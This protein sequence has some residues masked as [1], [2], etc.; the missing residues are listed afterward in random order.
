MARNL[1]QKILEDHLVEGNLTP[2]GEIAIRIDHTLLQDATGTMAMAGSSRLWAF[3]G[4]R[5]KRRPST[6]T[7]ICCKPILKN[8]DDHR[9]LMTASAK[10]GLHFSPPGNGI[11]HQGAHGTVWAGRARPCWARTVIRPASAGVIHAG[12]RRPAAWT[13]PMAMAGCP[14]HVPCPRVLGGQA[15]RSPC[16][17]GSA[18]RTSFR[19]CCGVTMSRAA[20]ARWWN[21]TVRAWPACRPRTGKPSATWARNWGPPAP[22]SPRTRGPGNTWKPGPGRGLGGT[23]RGRRGRL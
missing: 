11:S 18:P 14:Y 5:W 21:I 3:P 9:Y 8:P 13:W 16:R 22:S 19:K 10:Y 6:W 2:G 12:H 4:S 7:T 1:T 15:D 20:W 17:P 23:V